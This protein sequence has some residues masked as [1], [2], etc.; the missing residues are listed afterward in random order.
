[1]IMHYGFPTVF[2]G[3]WQKEIYSNLCMCTYYQEIEILLRR[4]L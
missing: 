1:M 4:F 3:N 2:V